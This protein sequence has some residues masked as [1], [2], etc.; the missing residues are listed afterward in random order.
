M[1][2]LIIDGQLSAVP[3]VRGVVHVGA[4][5]GQEVAFYAMLKDVPAM[6]IEPLPRLIP[7]IEAE[8]AANPQGDFT[9]VQACCS[10]VDGQEVDF[11]VSPDPI[12]QASSILAP[13]KVIEQF[14]WMAKTETVK[15]Q[16]VTLDTLLARDHPDFPVNMLAI[17]TQ[18]ADLKVL[19]GAERTLERCDGVYVEVSDEAFYQGGCTFKEIID[20]LDPRGFGLYRA[21]VTPA[22]WGNAFFKRRRS[23]QAEEIASIAARNIAL[24]RP[25]RESSVHRGKMKGALAVNGRLDQTHGFRTENRNRDEW[26]EIDLDG[27]REVA[28]IVLVGPCMRNRF[29]TI[30]V[31]V[32][33]DGED[34]QPVYDYAAAGKILTRFDS[35][36][37]GRR[38]SAVRVESRA[39]L[40]ML[41]Q[42]MV[43]APEGAA[44]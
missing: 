22:G 35:I 43:I 11:H 13:G 7:M 34:W 15:M 18:G 44:S 2:S 36:P 42:V 20:F 24:G 40:L 23:P 28:E 30:R 14:P 26:L 9:I 33:A 5:V 16:T 1:A 19:R 39:D 29:G 38:I 41:S 21:I 31:L 32:R 25:T 10:D 8:V 4:N 37:V 6:L 27:E 12:G 17:D 3:R